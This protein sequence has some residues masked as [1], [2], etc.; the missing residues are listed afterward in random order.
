[1]LVA[2]AEAGAAGRLLTAGEE[3]IIALGGAGEEAGTELDT[4]VAGWL[5]VSRARRAC[6]RA[7]SASFS[8]LFSCSSFCLSFSFLSICRLLISCCSLNVR[9]LSAFSFAAFWK[10]AKVEVESLRGFWALV[11]WD[12]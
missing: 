3:D 5:L 8:F 1:M 10:A 7:S 12:I 2:G 6:S 11:C 9:S 4:V